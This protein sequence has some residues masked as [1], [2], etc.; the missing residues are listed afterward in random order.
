M[1][2]KGEVYVFPN[3]LVSVKSSFFNEPTATF[4]NDGEVY[5]YDDLKNDG[6]LDFIEDSGLTIFKG[7]HIQKI[8]GSQP[9]YFN[10]IL[11]QNTSEEAPFHL[12]NQINAYGLVNF[13]NGI[14][15]NDN[16]GGTFVFRE[17]AAH[18]N[19]SDFSHVNGIVEKIGDKDFIYPIGDGG[20]YRFAAVKTIDTLINYQIKYYLKNSDDLFPHNLRSGIVSLINNKEYWTIDPTGPEQDIMISLSWREETSQEEIIAAPK[21]DNIHIV[22]WDVETNMWV[23]EG[24]IVNIN[25]KTVTTGVSKF[26]VFTLARVKGNENLPCEIIVYNAVTPNNDGVNDYFRIDNTNNTCAQ[27]L[28]VQIFNRWGVKVFESKNYGVEGNVFRGYS[29]G[30][31]TLNSDNLLPSGTYFYVLNYEYESDNGLKHQKKAGY[32]FLSGN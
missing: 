31:S 28:N 30:R 20:Y 12:Y 14:V 15:H 25:E 11:F 17:K 16:L 18:T 29:E 23:D 2:N 9:I 21:E 6:I 3:T 10:D 24:G 26:G 19:T 4:I 22:R 27:N 13:S 32:L 7:S 5:L 1:H 8:H